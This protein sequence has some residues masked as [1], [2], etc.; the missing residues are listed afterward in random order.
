LY[1]KVQHASSLTQLR[2]AAQNNAQLTGGSSGHPMGASLLATDVDPSLPRQNIKPLNHDVKTYPGN[3]LRM[4]KCL[5]S[6]V[7][8]PE[9]GAIAPAL[10]VG[11]IDLIQE[12]HVLT[13]VRPSVSRSES[14]S[15]TALTRSEP[16]VG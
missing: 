10:K 11:K 5:L 12:E 4:L 13:H 3:R 7:A 8:D 6:A 2:T 15:L 14:G 16:V 9:G 1:K